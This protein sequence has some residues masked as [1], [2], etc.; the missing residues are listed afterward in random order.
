MELL[1][2]AF[3]L[4]YFTLVRRVDRRLAASALLPVAIGVVGLGFA[5]V[6]MDPMG[7]P[8]T[9]DGAMHLALVAVSALAAIAAV[10]LAGFGW[11]P[12][13]DARGLA[14]VSFVLLG[15]MLASG[16]A[17][18]IVGATGWPGIGLLQ[19][20]N[21]GAFGLWQVAT[22]VFLLKPGADLCPS[23]GAD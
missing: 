1:T 2:I 4:G 22:A 14:R 13:R 17:S 12:V 15:G 5:R 3:G 6:P 20:I 16:V 10:F 7:S 21:T 19:R 23:P 18:D 9:V 8:V 11:R